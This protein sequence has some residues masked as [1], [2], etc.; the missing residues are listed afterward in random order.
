MKASKKTNPKTQLLGAYVPLGLFEGIQEWV[1]MNEERST[2]TFIR[3]AAREKLR[4]DG[5]KIKMDHGA[6]V[7][8]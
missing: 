1:A 4:R 6:L 5:I 7:T 2:S 8:K 3:E